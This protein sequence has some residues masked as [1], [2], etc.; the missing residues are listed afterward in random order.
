MSNVSTSIPADVPGCGEPATTRIEIYVPRDGEARG[1]LDGILYHCE[2]HAGEIL[3]VI[4]WDTGNITTR[5]TSL[6]DPNIRCGS[7]WDFVAGRAIDAPGTTQ[8]SEPD[9]FGDDHPVIVAVINAL[10]FGGW[11]PAETISRERAERLLDCWAHRGELTDREVDAVLARFPEAPTGSATGPVTV[12]TAELVMRLDAKVRDV[13]DRERR[14]FASGYVQGV[15]ARLTGTGHAFTV[16]ADDEEAD[17]FQWLCRCGWVTHQY[18]AGS[19]QEPIHKRLTGH[20][21]EATAVDERT[22]TALEVDGCSCPPEV[23]DHRHKLYVRRL[24]STGKLAHIVID[25]HWTGGRM[26]TLCWPLTQQGLEAAQRWVSEHAAQWEDGS[27]VTGEVLARR[28]EW[29]LR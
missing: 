19:E 17:K 22:A 8:P 5:R 24:A 11:V 25:A 3:E 16:E 27:P 6:R 26:E 4:S 14:A 28:G 21:F 10:T 9:V 13:E 2:Q 7:G 18:P 12:E 23:G 29:W 20:V 15:T 1:H